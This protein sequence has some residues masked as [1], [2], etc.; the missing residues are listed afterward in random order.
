MK[1][2][3]VIVH[4]SSLDAFAERAG[5]GE[6]EALADRIKR[7]VLE[8]NGP[9]Y[10]ID[11]KWPFTNWSEPRYKLVI[12]VQLQ[13]E[14]NWIHFED[15]M[16]EWDIFLSHFRTRLKKDKVT[17]VVLG[18]VWYDPG[19][20]AGCVSDAYLALK[21]DFRVSV[22]ETLVGCWSSAA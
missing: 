13:R 20:E 6:A 16:Q 19:G 10:V 14:I 8:Q 4:L 7:A 3:L 11:Q 17:S 18:G 5:M 12:S 21:K 22:D 2:A 15:D 1:Q 9:V